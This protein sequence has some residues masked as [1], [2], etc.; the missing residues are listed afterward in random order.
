MANLEK[1]LDREL[2]SFSQWEELTQA[3]EKGLDY[4]KYADPDFPSLNMY[5]IRMAQE[6]GSINFDEH[7][8]LLDPDISW[9]AIWE[10]RVK[11]IRERLKAEGKLT[12]E[13]PQN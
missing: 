7:P 1:K 6:E 2:F 10:E 5:E 3:A 12:D 8:E 4:M 13:K 9:Q 11:V